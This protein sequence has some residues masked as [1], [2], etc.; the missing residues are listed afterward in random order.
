[1]TL[2]VFYFLPEYRPD[3]GSHCLKSGPLTLAARPPPI[4]AP[5]LAEGSPSVLL[6]DF[7]PEH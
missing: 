3:T 6:T 7:F 5:A 4:W 1:M 2:P